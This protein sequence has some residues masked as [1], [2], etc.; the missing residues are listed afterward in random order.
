MCQKIV[1]LPAELTRDRSAAKAKETS[2]SNVASLVLGRDLISSCGLTFPIFSD[3]LSFSVRA[4][5]FRKNAHE[6]TPHAR[7]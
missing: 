5:M 1:M 3:R 2:D 7:F 4:C 6:R